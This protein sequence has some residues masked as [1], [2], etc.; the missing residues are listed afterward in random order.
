MTRLHSAFTFAL[1][2]ALLA[3]VAPPSAAQSC[4]PRFQCAGARCWYIML[5]N[6][7]FDAPPPGCSDWAGS[8]YVTSSACFNSKA[9][10]LTGS[11]SFSQD[12]SVPSTAEGELEIALEFATFGSPTWWDR[13]VVELRDPAGNLLEQKR[14]RTDLG[15]FYCRRVDDLFFGNYSNSNLRLIVR[16]DIYTAGVQYQVNWVQLFDTVGYP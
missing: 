4:T 13:I 9:A 10:V 1:T 14:I 11:N 7:S 15:P 5:N 6:S 2:F 12:F 8:P 3:L 16:S